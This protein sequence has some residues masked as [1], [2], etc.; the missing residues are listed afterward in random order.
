MDDI[1]CHTH[2]FKGITAVCADSG[3]QSVSFAQY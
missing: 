2:N 1:M 3:T